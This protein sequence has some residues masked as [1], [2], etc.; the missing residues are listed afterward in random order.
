MD[1]L[2]ISIMSELVRD[3]RITVS[4]LA[5]KL[6]V[7]RT[8]LDSRI[9]KL[10]ESGFIRGFTAILD[11][12][13]IGYSITAF[14]LVQI[15]RRKPEQDRSNQEIFIEEIGRES[16]SRDDLPWVEEAHIIT[17]DYDILLK[18]RARD[19]D[20]LTRFLITELARHPDVERTHTL[21]VLKSP[22]SGLAPLRKSFSP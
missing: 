2:D 7:P 10:V 3:G 4:D 22:Y 19:M 12:K 18:V 20:E 13:K 17:G 8:T 14:V 1:E 6:G 5:K 9:R 11:H 21:M 15:R 16:E